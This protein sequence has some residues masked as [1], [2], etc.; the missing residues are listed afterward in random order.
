[1]D[2]IPLI[3]VASG[4]N[5]VPFILGLSGFAIF[6]LGVILSGLWD[7]GFKIAVSIAAVGFALMVFAIGH[8][9]VENTNVTNEKRDATKDNIELMQSN[10]AEKYAIEADDISVPTNND[11]WIIGS[12]IYTVNVDNGASIVEMDVKFKESGEPT[13]V[14]TEAITTEEVEA[15]VRTGS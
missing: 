10:I 3:D 6:G 14:V 4:S 13:I 9:T 5:V 11:S 12:G 1:M 15:L 7:S 2:F 8:L